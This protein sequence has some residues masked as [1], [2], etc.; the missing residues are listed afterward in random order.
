MI[1][2]LTANDPTV[3]DSGDGTTI[4]DLF[5]R[6]GARRPDALALVDAPNRGSFTDGAPRRLTFAEADRVVSAIA[7]RLRR[8]NLPADAIVAIQMP[9]TVESA[10]ALKSRPSGIASIASVIMK[11][12]P[13][14]AAVSSKGGVP[15][16]KSICP[17]RLNPGC[18]H[19]SIFLRDVVVA[20]P[21]RLAEFAADQS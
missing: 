15:K 16:C 7:G 11:R 13:I 18:Q 12:Q 4:D 21:R 8:L 19:S 17:Q 20:F 2:G 1:L 3:V 14:G 5:R 6:A 10:A 9:S